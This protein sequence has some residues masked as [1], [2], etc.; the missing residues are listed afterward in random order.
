MFTITVF[1][2]FIVSSEILPPTNLTNVSHISDTEFDNDEGL[3][4]CICIPTDLTPMGKIFARD[5]QLKKLRTIKSFPKN[6]NK[7]SFQ[8][9][10]LEKY[11]WLEYSV[12]C[13]AL[14]C[15]S[16][17]QYCSSSSV[18]EKEFIETGFRLWVHD[19]LKPQHN[20]ICIDI[21]HVEMCV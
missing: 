11:D 16:C 9:S 4:D 12:V 6:K 5:E 13:D 18:I 14:F 20:L 15:Y 2:L 17:R 1:L 8:L 7:R 19:L 21:C 10:W 3:L